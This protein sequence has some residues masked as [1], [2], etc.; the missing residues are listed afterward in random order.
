MTLPA[1]GDPI[2]VRGPLQIAFTLE[3]TEE[4]KPHHFTLGH[5]WMVKQVVSQCEV[6]RPIKAKTDTLH[7]LLFHRGVL[8]CLDQSD[9]ARPDKNLRRFQKSHTVPHSET[10]LSRLLPRFT[11]LIL[12]K[13]VLSNPTV[14]P[15]GK[16]REK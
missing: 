8:D 4:C 7:A 12:G 11:G 9:S 6:Q 10:V 13:S 14:T 2:A 16:E 3:E 5:R 15:R 1:L